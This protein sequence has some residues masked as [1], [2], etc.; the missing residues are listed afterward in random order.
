MS[1]I[2]FLFYFFFSSYFFFS[3][4]F[5]FSFFYFSSLPFEA[6]SVIHSHVVV[7]S[8]IGLLLHLLHR[9]VASASPPPPPRG[10][11]QSPAPA[12]SPTAP[13]VDGRRSEHRRLEP[14]HLKACRL[15]PPP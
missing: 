14:H 7:I 8:S 6:S 12:A 5:A 9:P 10:A 11:P 13:D 4:F 1:I 3:F 2:P 15:L